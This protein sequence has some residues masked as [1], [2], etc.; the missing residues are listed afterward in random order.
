[1]KNPIR[2]IKIFIFKI[3]FRSGSSVPS[4]SGST[5]PATVP[6]KDSHE[7]LE[8][9]LGPV[10]GHDETEEIFTK[11]IESAT[12]LTPKLEKDEKNL[13]LSEFLNLYQTN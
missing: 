1:M 3:E 2:K 6:Q 4:L 7:F 10:I 13:E 11:Y 9:E 5:S 8:T 12:L